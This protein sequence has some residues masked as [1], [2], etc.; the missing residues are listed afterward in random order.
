MSR[1]LSSGSI[2]TWSGGTLEAVFQRVWPLLQIDSRDS[3]PPMLW[4]INTMRSKAGSLV[5][6]V[7]LGA[8]VVERLAEPRAGGQDRIARRVEEH[9][10]LVAFPQLG[11][12]RSSLIALSHASG[13]DISPCTKTTGIFPGW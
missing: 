5:L 6:R 1:S 10:E 8:Q 12:P 11:V 2:S 4:P 7:E 3:S 13:L 9:P